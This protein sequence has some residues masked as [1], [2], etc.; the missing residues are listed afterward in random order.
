MPRKVSA[1]SGVRGAVWLVMGGRIAGPGAGCKIGWQTNVSA[2]L[3]QPGLALPKPRDSQP[4][5]DEG[6]PTHLYS[7]RTRDVHRGAKPRRRAA[8][9]RS[10]QEHRGRAPYRGLRQAE[11]GAQA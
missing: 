5:T 6:N 4:P 2:I 11:E 9:C 3:L 1:C 10:A 7:W 8:A